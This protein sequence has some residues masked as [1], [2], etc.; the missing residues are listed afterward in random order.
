MTKLN[1]GQSSHRVRCRV[2]RH[3][4]T[5]M[6][7]DVQARAEEGGVKGPPTFGYAGRTGPERCWDCKV[8]R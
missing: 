3:R 1:P 7:E 8:R 5:N 6:P 2:G 4:W